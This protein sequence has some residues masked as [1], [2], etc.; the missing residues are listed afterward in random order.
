[1]KQALA[2]PF[3]ITYGTGEVTGRVGYDT[4]TLGDRGSLSIISQGFG[5]VLSSS[6]DFLT[7]SCDGLFVRS[8]R[9]RPACSQPPWARRS[10]HSTAFAVQGLAGRRS[11]AAVLMPAAPVCEGPSA[12]CSCLDRTPAAVHFP[13]C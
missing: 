11:R 9:L 6:S 7:A 12:A 13:T 4:V 3:S 8:P 5:Q 10:G 2:R 1:M